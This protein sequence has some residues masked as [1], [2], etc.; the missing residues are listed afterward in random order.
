M[1]DLLKRR[2]GKSQYVLGAECRGREDVRLAQRLA[3][4]CDL[5][6]TVYILKT[7]PVGKMT[8]SKGGGT[9]DKFRFFSR[10]GEFWKWVLEREP[11]A[12]EYIS[13]RLE[14]AD[15][16]DD[17]ISRTHKAFKKRGGDHLLV[18]YRQFT[19]ARIEL[20]KP[21]VIEREV[22]DQDFENNLQTVSAK[23]SDMV[24]WP[25]N[26]DYIYYYK[27]KFQK[28]YGKPKCLCLDL[29][30][31]CNKN[32][33][34]CQYHA[35]HSP[36]RDTIKRGEIMPLELFYRVLDEAKDWDPKPSI[37]PT[38]SGEP[39]IYPHLKEVYSYA[40]QLGFLLSVT[41]N[42]MALNEKACRLIL[43]EGVDSVLVSIDAVD[44][45]SYAELQP[46]GKLSDVRKN[47]LRLLDMR[48]GKGSPSVG[49]HFVMEERNKH[50]FADYLNFWGTRLDYVSMAI[51][52]DQFS[53][54]QLTLPSWYP[55]GRHRACWGAW[56]TLY[57]RWDGK[58]SFCG[59]DIDGETS[60]INVNDRSLLDAWNSEEFWRWRDA[61]LNNDKS[62]IYCRACPDWSGLRTMTVEEGSWK[63][64]RTP[65]TE[66]YS[67]IKDR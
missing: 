60:H 7:N 65:F 59:F 66:V 17:L 62:I 10:R 55:I 45:E 33:D 19:P 38:F 35:P 9:L 5:N 13:L 14:N 63:I 51:K 53:A 31:S 27:E 37:S 15:L 32:C 18:D 56:T 1:F 44:E 2:S 21:S 46:P 57:I 25:Q 52:Q 39:L 3:E 40:K 36:Y 16:P 23:N 64:S 4:K 50:Q 6:P 28:Y 8:L 47:V 29:S 58:V 20:F 42:G 48:G 22:S 43:D 54:S 26:K 24:L 12:K 67:R 41:T 11:E 34:K 49:V 61:Q 30:P